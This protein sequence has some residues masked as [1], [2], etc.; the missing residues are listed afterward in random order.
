MEPSSQATRTVAVIRVRG[1]GRSSAS[2]NAAAEEPLEIRLH[3]RPFAVLMT[4]GNL[5]VHWPEGNVLLSG[6][7]LD[8]ESLEPDYNATVCVEA[9]PGK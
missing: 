9:V 4:P 5:A 7:A 6:S 3:R 1:D 2:D 8:P